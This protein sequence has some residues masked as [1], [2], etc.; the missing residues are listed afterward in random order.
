MFT[1]NIVKKVLCISLVSVFL[2]SST[3]ALEISETNIEDDL[4]PLI[5]LEVI[6]KIK[7][8]R[9]LDIIDLFGKPDFYVKIFVNDVE[10][11]SDV[12]QDQKYVDPSWIVTQNVP[13]DQEF[14]NIKIQLWDQN[15][16][17]D[18][19]CDIEGSNDKE[20][21]LVYSL[22][23]GHWTGDDFIGFSDVSGYGRLN[24][25]DDGTI[26]KINR[27]CELWFDISQNDYDGDGIPYW[28]EI[29]AYGTNPEVDDRGRDDDDDEVPIEWEFKW[30]YDPF[31]WNNHVSLDPDYDGIDNYEEF[32]TSGL[33]TDPFRKDIL[34]ELDQMKIG[35]NGEGSFAPDSS[36]DLIIDAFSKYNIMFYIDDSGEKISFDD[37]TTG[38]ELRNIYFRYFLE[39]DPN[40]WKRGVFHYGLVIYRSSN[41]PGFVFSTEFN[42]KKLTD[43]FQ[44]ST[45]Y[46]ETLPDRS[47]F[48]NFLRYKSFNSEYKRAIIYAGAMMHETGHVLGINRWNTPGCDT[49]SVFPWG[50]VWWLYRNYKSCMNYNYVYTL[51]DYSD[52]S[53]GEVDYDDWERIDLAR[54]QR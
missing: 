45:R 42:G 30:D 18:K 40:N 43:C 29:N 31:N 35:P 52:G 17:G 26:Y 19:L 3:S 13:D 22:K 48:Y 27:D 47:P 14:V 15:N 25:C 46:H 50:S 20:V 2:I 24:G 38:D 4:D 5:D 8:I 23:T 39:N 1:R 36:K 12:W 41:H 49:D 33:N 9:A 6:V 53:H 7:K 11:V 54:F 37:S 28:T 34:L 51:V 32:L 44:V 10:Y 21:E 16:Y